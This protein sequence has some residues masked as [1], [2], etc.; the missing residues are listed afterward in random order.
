MSEKNSIEISLKC[1]LDI[2]VAMPAETEKIKQ[3]QQKTMKFLS[4]ENFHNLKQAEVY[5]YI[6]KLHSH[7]RKLMRKMEKYKRR[8]VKLVRNC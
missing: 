1:P 7:I 2:K 8:T 5:K 6:V 4:I 3:K